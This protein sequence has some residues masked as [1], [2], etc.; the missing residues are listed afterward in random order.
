[1]AAKDFMLGVIV[2]AVV[3]R[4]EEPGVSSAIDQE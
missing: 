2:Q 1:M 4:L 3:L